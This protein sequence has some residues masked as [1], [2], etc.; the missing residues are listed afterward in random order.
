MI[1][2]N[3]VERI[4]EVEFSGE[5]KAMFEKSVNSVKGLVEACKGINGALA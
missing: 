4:V 2:E 5:E 1:G 3:G